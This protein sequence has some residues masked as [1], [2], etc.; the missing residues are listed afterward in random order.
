[1]SQLPRRVACGLRACWAIRGSSYPRGT[2]LLIFALSCYC[3]VQSAWEGRPFNIVDATFAL[4]T[5]YL[6]ASSFLEGFQEK[7]A[8][9]SKP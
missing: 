7:E 2:H 9:P 6:V 4:L 1:M 3:L 8:T 5:G